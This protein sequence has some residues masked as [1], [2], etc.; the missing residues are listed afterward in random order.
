MESKTEA[1]DAKSGDERNYDEEL[2]NL[3]N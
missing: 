2:K 1:I 3:E